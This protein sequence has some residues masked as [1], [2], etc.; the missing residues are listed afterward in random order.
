MT[1]RF[2]EKKRE[3]IQSNRPESSDAM[4]A[5]VMRMRMRESSFYACFVRQATLGELYN[6]IQQGDGGW[7]FI[8][9][10]GGKQDDVI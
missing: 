8:E 1:S 10:S 2:L 5:V 7:G 6:G 9:W 4:G 3:R